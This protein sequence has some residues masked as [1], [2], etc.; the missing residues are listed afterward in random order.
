MLTLHNI[1][2]RLDGRQILQDVSFDLRPQRL[3]ALVGKNGSGK[4]TLLSCVNQLFPYQGEILEGEKNLALLPPRE[5]AKTIAILPQTL[6]APH[7]TAEEM[8]SFGRTPYMDFAGRLMQ[9]D[10][11]AV[12]KAM[13]DTRCEAF[14]HRYVDTLSGGERQ[15]IALAMI[16]AQSTPIALLDEPT[17]HMDQR[18]A[19]D[20]LQMLT[21]L[22][23]Q[24]KKTFLVVLHDLSTA[25]QYADDLI[26][27]EDGKVVFAGTKEQCLKTEV[28]EN[29]FDL[30]RYIA[31]ERIFFAP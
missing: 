17:A 29:T 28:L 15:R 1:S 16:L 31:K 23:I 27:L 26:V 8:V 21:D 9:Y 7:I 10:R 20:F 3:T 14:V 30:Q 4:S 12:E 25:V 5:R 19:A 11:Q 2:V 24:E 22:K 13:K 6:P 18:Y